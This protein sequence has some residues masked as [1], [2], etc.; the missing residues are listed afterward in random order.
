MY[1]IAI[2][3]ALRTR[4]YFGLTMSQQVEPEL[5]CLPSASL[6][7]IRDSRNLSL[8]ST[9]CPSASLSTFTLRPLRIASSSVFIRTQKLYRQTQQRYLCFEQRLQQVKFVQ[10]FF[11]LLFS[12]SMFSF[13]VL[14]C[15]LHLNR[16]ALGQQCQSD[17][18]RIAIVDL[19]AVQ[20]IHPW[21]GP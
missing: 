6:S 7:Y 17:G 8:I 19:S 13:P 2:H 20:S 11:G 18:L 16:F 14:S 5:T 4:L 12:V 3:S 1:I 21:S 9:G 10:T 15:S